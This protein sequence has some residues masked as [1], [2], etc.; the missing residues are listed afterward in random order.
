MPASSP[1]IALVLVLASR[2][3]KS[4]YEHDDED[5]KTMPRIFRPNRARR[6]PSSSV[7]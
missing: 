3:Q 6:R 2:H 5:D 7:C 4:D 1:A